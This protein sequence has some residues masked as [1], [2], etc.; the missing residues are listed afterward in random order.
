VLDL[1]D[2]EAGFMFLPS[3]INRENIA[4]GQVENKYCPFI[5]AMAHLVTAHID[6]EARGQT[7]LKFPLHMLWDKA[8]KKE[9]NC[10]SQQLGI[11][12][13]QITTA[14]AAAE[15]AQQDFYATVRRRGREVLDNLRDEQLAVVVVG[16]PY[17]ICDPGVCQDLPFKLRKLGVLPIPMDYLPL[18][19]VDVSER[20][21]NMFWR[22]GQDILAAAT[23]IRDDPR[24]Q[25]I[26]LTNFNCGPDS[27][28]IS[29]FRQMMGD[30]PFL[31]LEVDDHTADAGIITR[32]EAFLESL[33]MRKGALL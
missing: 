29:F 5:P 6:V 7:P 17:N 3:I 18:D 15:A 11:S 1:L 27:F 24:L 33:K 19:T 13:G 16:R 22:S 9:L 26:Y 23:I 2:K 32:C 10:L 30:K 20:Y 12:T 14:M 4:P 25:A 21:D 31:E 28:L 8:K